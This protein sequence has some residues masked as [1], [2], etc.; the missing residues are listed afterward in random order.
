[1]ATLLF[2]AVLSVGSVSATENNITEINGHLYSAEEMDDAAGRVNAWTE[3]NGKSPI[4]V[5]MRGNRV[6]IELFLPHSPSV[7]PVKSPKYTEP[8]ILD[9]SSRVNRW[10]E[11]HRKLPNYVTISGRNVNIYEYLPYMG[12]NVYNLQEK[13]SSNQYTQ[14]EIEDAS[15]R[16][17]NWIKN[18]N[19][20]PIYVTING[21]NVM[22]ENFLPYMSYVEPI[23]ATTSQYGNGQLNNLAGLSGLDILAS[24]INR[25]L[26]HALPAATTAAGVE[27]TKLGDCWGLSDWAG[28]VLADN[29]YTVR[30][31]QG[32][33]SQSYNHRWLHVLVNGRWVSF[34]PSAVTR[35]YG[36]RHYSTI[37]ASVRNIVKTFN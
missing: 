11:V 15:L 9:A 1:M 16:V 10:M 31:V 4:F 29:G 12:T 25:N 33:T 21:K 19:R 17:N 3:N 37:W 13:R 26:N 36:S 35:R 34:D 5:T 32:A 14:A 7:E 30:I 6:P 8:Q 18:N 22:I 27:R 28:T 23:K 24:Y 2:L 20:L